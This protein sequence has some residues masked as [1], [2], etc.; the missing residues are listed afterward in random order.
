VEKYRKDI[1]VAYRLR[2]DRSKCKRQTEIVAFCSCFER[3]VVMG[4]QAKAAVI[5]GVE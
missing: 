1:K 2:A 3:L 4:E 5:T